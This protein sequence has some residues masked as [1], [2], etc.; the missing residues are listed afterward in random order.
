MIYIFLADGFEEVEALTPVD[1]LRRSGLSVVCVG[2]GKKLVEGAHKIVVEADVELSSCEFNLEGSMVVLPG[3]LKGTENLNSNEQVCRILEQSS[4]VGSL[5]A[6]CA[7]PSIL[8]RLNLLKGKKA[9]CYPGFEKFL[10]GAQVVNKDVVLSDRIITSKGAGTAQQF[11]FEIVKFMC[12]EEA[13]RKLQKEVQ[14]AF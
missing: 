8:G 10:F 14:W 9:C 7:A 3:G 12:G 5:A 11:S 13:S 6:I 4:K 2:V 1:Y